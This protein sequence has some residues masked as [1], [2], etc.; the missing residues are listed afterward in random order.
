MP[1]IVFSRP[2][3]LILVVRGQ[4]PRPLKTPLADLSRPD[5]AGFDRICPLPHL[6]RRV[7]SACRPLAVGR[8]SFASDGKLPLEDQPV[9]GVAGLRSDLPE[10][11]SRN[12]KKRAALRAKPSRHGDGRPGSDSWT[13][14]AKKKCLPPPRRRGRM[15]VR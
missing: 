12:R 8:K 6:R 13:R 11:E 3:R 15:T 2:R 7:R 10:S 1:V 4:T 14:D 5:V 9:R